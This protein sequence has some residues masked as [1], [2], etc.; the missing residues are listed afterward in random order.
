MDT[1]SLSADPVLKG[2]FSKMNHLAISNRLRSAMEKYGIETLEQAAEHSLAFWERKPGIGVWTI[3]E[4]RGMLR[5]NG[6]D[7]AKRVKN[8]K[9]GKAIS[10]EAPRPPV[11]GIPFKQMP[12][13]RRFI[14]ESGDVYF[15][16]AGELPYVKIGF[17]K[18]SGT[19]DRRYQLQIGNPLDLRILGVKAGGGRS[20][21]EKLHQQFAA[22]RM[23]GEWFRLDQ[24]IR[25]YI[26][27]ET[28]NH[29]RKL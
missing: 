16:Q 8:P 2:Y 25:Q 9:S 29:K 10:P 23:R 18:S 3:R 20:L 1:Y 14:S 24:E 13:R 5:A 15:I 6:F 26:A 4:L 7:F 12:D 27:T 22:H 19:E 11:V 17:C 28:D 21:E